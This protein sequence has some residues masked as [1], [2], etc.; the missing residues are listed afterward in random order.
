VG[1]PLG[2]TAGVDRADELRGGGE[3][4][5]RSVDYGLR[6]HR[7]DG[8]G[9]AGVAQLLGEPV[10][11]HPL[12]LG[13]EGIQGIGPGQGGI[14][15]ALHG[16]E[17]DLGSVAVTDDQLVRGGERREGLRRALDVMVLNRGVGLVVA[18]QQGV[19]AEGDHGQHASR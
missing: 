4:R 7:D 17:P 11:D 18:L 3:G 2:V 16:Q 8:T 10:A 6:H 19:A 9:D 5:I 15:L 1:E 12:G 13:T 14:A